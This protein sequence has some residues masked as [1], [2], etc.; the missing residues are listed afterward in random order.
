MMV[1]ADVVPGTDLNHAIEQGL[2]AHPNGYIHLHYVKPG[3]FAAR[4]IPLKV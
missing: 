2:K 4:V 1:D 3:C